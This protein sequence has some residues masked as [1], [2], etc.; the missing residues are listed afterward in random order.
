ELADTFR[1]FPD[2]LTPP[3]RHFI[4]RREQWLE[5]LTCIGPGRYQVHGSDVKVSDTPFA[6]LGAD[7]QYQIFEPGTDLSSVPTHEHWHTVDEGGGTSSG[8]AGLEL[9][10]EIG[11]RVNT[12]PGSYG[13]DGLIVSRIA[14]EFP[15]AWG[16]ST[17]VSV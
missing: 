3:R 5:F 17:L 15:P 4:N 6:S 1:R 16:A 12:D 9:S 10:T 13:F 8:T 7:G 2:Y 14:G 11:N